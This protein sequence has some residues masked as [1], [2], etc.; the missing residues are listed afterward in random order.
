MENLSKW[1]SITFITTKNLTN[2]QLLWSSFNYTYNYIIIT[3]HVD[4]ENVS[5]WTNVRTN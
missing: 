2:A 3:W 4:I 1:T 5:Q